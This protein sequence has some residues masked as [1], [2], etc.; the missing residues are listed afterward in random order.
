MSADHGRADA[1]AMTAFG[2]LLLEEMTFMVPA[3][4]VREQVDVRDVGIRV[5]RFRIVQTENLSSG[6]GCRRIQ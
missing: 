5:S 1:G 6:C 4:V 2:L 3:P